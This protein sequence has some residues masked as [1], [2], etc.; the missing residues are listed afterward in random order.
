MNFPDWKRRSLLAVAEKRLP[1]QP[2]DYILFK[3]SGS[4]LLVTAAMHCEPHD[5][6]V[7][8]EPTMGQRLSGL[9]WQKSEGTKLDEF[10]LD[11]SGFESMWSI[12][13]AVV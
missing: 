10:W 5:S 8:S 11:W 13:R 4:R 1:V 9:F 12:H 7:R 6:I 3:F 2:G